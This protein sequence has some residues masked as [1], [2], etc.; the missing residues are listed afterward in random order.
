MNVLQTLQRELSLMNSSV[1]IKNLK[2][3]CGKIGINGHVA[4]LTTNY[5]DKITAG[6]KI[7]ES[8]F[9]KN[10]VAP[11]Q[12]INDKDVIFLKKTA[13]PIVAISSVEKIKFF[14]PMGL[15]EAIK[16]METYSEG[17][18]LEDMFKTF[19]A[20]SQ[21]ATLIWLKS[22]LTIKP[23]K[24]EKLDRRSWVVLSNATNSWLF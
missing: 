22:V 23:I 21:Y 24:L 6:D 4:V 7:I 1:D 5:L 17:L 13:G 18:A 3:I 2:E 20:N 8:R 9:T 12:C 19:K 15:G 11:F 10:R 14:G 16:V